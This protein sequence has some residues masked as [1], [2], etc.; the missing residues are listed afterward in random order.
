VIFNEQDIGVAFV[1][2][3]VQV[4]ADPTAGDFPDIGTYVNPFTDFGFKRIFGQE[5]SSV[6]CIITEVQ[7]E[8][9]IMPG[10]F[11]K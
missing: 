11:I 1:G 4:L 3:P 2:E 5:M 10:S 7:N 9:G 6:V 8:W